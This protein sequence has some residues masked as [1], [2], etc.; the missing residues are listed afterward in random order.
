[1]PRGGTTITADE[2]SAV[3]QKYD[4]GPVRASHM[5]RIG[6]TRAPKMVMRTEKGMYLLKRRPP[7][8]EDIYHVAFS[9]AIQL[10]LELH[11][12]PVPGIVR[13]KDENT[14]VQHNGHV[15]EIFHFA[16]GSRYEPTPG[17]AEAAGRTLAEF[18]LALEDFPLNWR[19][20]K[21]TYHDADGVRHYLKRIGHKERDNPDHAVHEM[22]AVLMRLY[23]DSCVRVNQLGYDE[24]RM[25]IIHSDWH[26]GNMLFE[27]DTVS[28]V[29][30]FDSVK[31]APAVC[32]IGNGMLQ[33]SIIGG[34]NDT[35]L[36]PSE[37]DT[38]RMFAFVNGYRGVRELDR[39][40]VESLPDLMIETMIAESALPIAATGRF[41]H[42]AGSAFLTMILRKCEW[43]R[44]RRED[45]IRLLTGE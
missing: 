39:D 30:D 44:D 22:I 9:H 34:L 19:P 3:M 8:K 11:G 40:R 24:W 32:D 41:A 38:E 13:T 14:T 26:P 12:F 2:L 43:I 5:L 23:N 42:H 16:P 37:P 17:Q 31:L 25:G 27:G 1:M 4:I 15:Y 33:F 36:W 6:N 45:L 7:G 21:N 20:L 28:A 10:H 18:H 35:S 29:F